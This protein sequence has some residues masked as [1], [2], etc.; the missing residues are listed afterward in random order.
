MHPYYMFLHLKTST[1]FTA[2]W[3]KLISWGSPTLRYHFGAP[4]A[5]LHYEV[6]KI[7][8]LTMLEECKIPWFKKKIIDLSTILLMISLF[9]P[10][11]D[12]IHKANV[13]PHSVSKT[14]TLI[15]SQL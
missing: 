6:C 11:S 3:R 14:E 2:I 13:I 10:S 1:N 12:A 5:F 4:K 9:L 8:L 15:Q 7:L